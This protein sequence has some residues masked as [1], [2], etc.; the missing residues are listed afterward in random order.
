MAAS[1]IGC[2]DRDAGTVNLMHASDQLLFK[3]WMHK[4]GIGMIGCDIRDGL[5][6]GMTVE[7]RTC[8]D[9][10]VQAKLSCDTVVRG[11]VASKSISRGRIVVSVSDDAVLMPHT[12][13]YAGNG[14]FP[15]SLYMLRLRPENMYN[16]IWLLQHC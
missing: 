8:R 5:H 13:R 14:S 10:R 4:R 6:T 7:K 9:R 2:R 3:R 15:D 12:S 1:I 16:T 11:V